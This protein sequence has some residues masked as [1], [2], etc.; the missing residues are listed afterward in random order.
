MK[1][2]KSAGQNNPKPLPAVSNPFED[3]PVDF[4]IKRGGL[5]IFFDFR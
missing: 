2:R 4:V 1:K 5:Y 3:S